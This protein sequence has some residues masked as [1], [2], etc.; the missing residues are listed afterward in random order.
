MGKPLWEGVRP[1][2]GKPRMP[3]GRRYGW[4]RVRVSVE[5]RNKVWIC[6]KVWVSGSLPFMGESMGDMVGSRVT[7]MMRAPEVA[8]VPAK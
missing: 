1:D 8:P 5:V 6:N 3:D 7:G 4:A 2:D